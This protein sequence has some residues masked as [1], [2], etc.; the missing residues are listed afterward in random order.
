M[1]FG[2]IEQERCRR[3]FPALG[4]EFRGRPLVYLDGPAG[5]QVPQAVIDAIA[6]VYCT[7]NANTHGQFITSVEADAALWRAREVVAAF[8]GADAPERISFGANMTTLAFALS[9]ALARQ[10][11][12]GDEVVITQLD[13]EANRSPWA[14]LAEHGAVVREARL[15]PSGRLDEADLSSKIRPRTRLVA[16][17]YSSNALG[18]VNDVALARRL[19]QACGAWLIVDAVHYA[20]HFPIDVQ[21]LQ[22][23]FLLCSAYKFYGPHIGVLYSRRGIL[24]QLRTDV[25][26]TQEPRPPYLIETGTLNLAA[27]EGVRAAVEYL[28]SFGSGASLRSRIVDAMTAIGRHEHALAGRY[29]AAVTKLPGVTAWGDDFSSAR[30][31]PTVSVTVTG[32]SPTALAKA[33]GERG[34]CVWDGDFYAARAIEV[35]GLAAAGGVLRTGMSM[36][37]SEQDVDRLVMALEELAA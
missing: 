25:L 31:A 12:P 14:Q 29:H 32:H 35:L 21:E 26:P 4:R 5:T 27:I 17:G 9:R 19:T 37:S 6:R 15:L 10:L 11:Q 7:Y 23:D 8:L 36:Y 24:E 20:P 18:T 13:H 1:P 3:D 16:I 30:R 34:I 28:A 33:L 22:P 2:R